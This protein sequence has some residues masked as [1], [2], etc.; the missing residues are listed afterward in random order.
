MALHGFRKV[1]EMRQLPPV[2]RREMEWYG[3]TRFVS[4]ALRGLSAAAD[5]S[6][7]GAVAPPQC[8]VQRLALTCAAFSFTA[9]QRQDGEPCQ[10]APEPEALVAVPMVV[11]YQG[12]RASVYSLVGMPRFGLFFGQ[13]SVLRMRLPLTPRGRQAP[14]GCRTC[15]DYRT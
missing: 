7:V 11:P 14:C 3:K 2:A 13:G 6:W 4:C 15:R 1:L 5:C 9:C 8:F 12:R 10:Q